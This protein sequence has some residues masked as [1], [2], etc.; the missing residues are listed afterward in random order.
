MKLIPL[1]PRAIRHG[2]HS[3][4]GDLATYPEKPVRVVV[5]YVAGQGVDI[6]MR[7]VSER[8]SR[9]L[10]KEFVIENK[11]GAAGNLG[12]QFVKQASADGYTLLACTNATHAANS[13]LYPNSGIVP[14]VDFV[15][16]ALT[17][18]FP[19]VVAVSGDSPLNDL[20]DLVAAARAKPDTINVALPHT[21]ARVV[22]ELLRSEAKAPLFGVLYRG[23]PLADI[24]TDR[25]QV[26]VD[27]VAATRR[28]I[29]VGEAEGTGS[30]DRRTV[31]VAAR[32]EDCGAT[33]CTGVRDRGLDG[34]LRAARRRPRR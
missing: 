28:L 2:V 22:F 20:Q 8:L 21:T 12:T 27:T 26:L 30:N 34:A 17:G 16:I 29:E 19:M 10:G 24:V 3:R 1:F 4:T 13:T 33:G 9:E 14:E 18:M 11:S 6:T 23:L 5:P 15:P 31:S 32:R 7:V 25:V